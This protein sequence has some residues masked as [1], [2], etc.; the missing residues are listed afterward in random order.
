MA[1]SGEGVFS[2]GVD[3]LHGGKEGK[4]ALFRKVPITAI[5]ELTG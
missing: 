1:D 3:E 2:P 4:G 5:Q